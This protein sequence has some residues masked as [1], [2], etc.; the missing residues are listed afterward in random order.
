MA[1]Q[2][3]QD[4]LEVQDLK[5][6]S[7]SLERLEIRGTWD[8]QGNLENRVSED[9]L[10][11]KVIQ[12]TSLFFLV[13]LEIRGLLETVDLQDLPDLKGIVE[14]LVLLEVQDTQG[15]KEI[16][17]IEGTQVNQVWSVL[18]VP[19]AGR[20]FLVFLVKRV[21]MVLQDRRAFRDS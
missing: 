18:K 14:D 21:L 20:V 17:A 5:D 9:V 1:N 19:E 15:A 4:H 12:V 10:D 11:L 16:K 13:H 8:V 3:M 6:S 2:V 7:A